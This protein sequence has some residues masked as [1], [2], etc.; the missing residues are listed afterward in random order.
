MIPMRFLYVAACLLAPLAWGLGSYTV[1]RWVE[2]RL[3]RRPAP[4]EKPGRPPLPDLEY[5]L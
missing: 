1:A 4:T 2:A 5:Y 3:P